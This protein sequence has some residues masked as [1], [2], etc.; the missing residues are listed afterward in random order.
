MTKKL[1]IVVAAIALASCDAGNGK[2]DI[3]G[4]MPGMKKADV[5]ALAESHKWRCLNESKTGETCYTMSGAMRV[6]Y[7]TNTEGW[8]VS[9]LAFAFYTDQKVPL[10]IQAEDI[11]KQF[12]RMLLISRDEDT[13]R[14]N[15]I[16]NVKQS[17]PTPK[18]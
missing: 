16:Q 8:P 6:A 4:F 1:S 11:S 5:H 7:A 9:G 17:N 18:F 3:M 2:N 13:G 12:G 10:E 15:S 14:Q